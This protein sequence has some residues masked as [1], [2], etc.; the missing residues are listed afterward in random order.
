[1]STIYCYHGSPGT[2]FDFD[3]LRKTL[4]QQNLV[5]V[6]RK[7]YPDDSSYGDYSEGAAFDGD[8]KRILLGYSW[9]ALA[10]LRDGAA[11][12]DKVKSIILVAPYL[13]GK[14]ISAGKRFLM[15]WK[16]PGHTIVGLMADSII[17]KLLVKSSSP[18]KVPGEYAALKAKLANV[19]VLARSVME[20]G[21]PGMSAGEACAVLKEQNIP[22]LLIV[23]RKDE[24]EGSQEYGANVEKWLSPSKV[25]YVE[26]G[27]HALLWTHPELL[28]TEIGTFLEDT[29]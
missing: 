4:P 24:N 1:M 21:D 13:G 20:K 11:N 25:L 14:D 22:V 16:F 2:A 15:T 23:G 19:P 28:G 9:G 18:Q 17:E 3:L 26:D 7:G 29:R 27:G 5:A 12:V 8:E 6:K 10:A